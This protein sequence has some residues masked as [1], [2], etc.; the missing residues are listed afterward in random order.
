MRSCYHNPFLLLVLSNVQAAVSSY[1]KG[2][3]TAVLLDVP[4]LMGTDDVHDLWGV[5]TAPLSILK[6][7]K[8]EKLK[9][10]SW[11]SPRSCEELILQ[12]YERFREGWS[13]SCQY[14]IFQHLPAH[15]TICTPVCTKQSQWAT[16]ST[17][18]FPQA[19]V[20][21]LHLPVSSSADPLFSS[22]WLY[23]SFHL[24]YVPRGQKSRQKHNLWC[25]VP[26][27]LNHLLFLL[28]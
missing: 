6:W 5:Q 17:V 14:G 21:Q 18:T 24:V 1:L 20:A 7:K 15:S 25:M 22:P 10:L 2:L 4:R 12:G 3:E 16:P 27:F 11:R 28:R 13:Y 26:C 23:S 8:T 9:F 19:L